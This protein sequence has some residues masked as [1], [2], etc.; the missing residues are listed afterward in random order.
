MIAKCL[1]T[2][3]RLASWRDVPQAIVFTTHTLCVSGTL[4]VSSFAVIPLFSVKSGFNS[5]GLPLPSWHQSVLTAPVEQ[6]APN[7]LS[8]HPSGDFAPIN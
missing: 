7:H 8:D 4:E 3:P 1:Q 6:Q 5:F 2:L